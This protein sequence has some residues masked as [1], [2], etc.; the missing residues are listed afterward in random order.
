L[1]WVITTPFGTPVD[2]DVNRM[3]AASPAEFAHSTGSGEKAARSAPEND[4]RMLE[5][6]ASGTSSKPTR[7]E[8]STDPSAS[9]SPSS[10]LAGAVARIRRGSAD[11]TIFSTR[12]A[13]EAV[14]I[15]T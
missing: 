3:W 11:C 12:A 10:L 7:T 13:G 8:E 5:T 2:P 1:A 6:S 9:T 14:S 4:A 15:G